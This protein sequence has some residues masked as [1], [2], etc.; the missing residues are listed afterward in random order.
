VAFVGYLPEYS[1]S[2]MVFNPKA[3]QTVPGFGGNI[4]ATIWRAAMA[5]FLEGKTTTAFPPAD[6]ELMGPPPPA[7]QPQQSRPERDSDDAEERP[8]RETPAEEPPTEEEPPVEQPP[9]E[10]P[11][12]GAPADGATPGNGGGPPPG[13]GG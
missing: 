1:A 7:P 10:Q 5:P 8:A 12:G 2:V 9:G 4:P 3:K 13:N 11:D 6:P